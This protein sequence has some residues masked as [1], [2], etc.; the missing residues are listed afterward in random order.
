MESRVIA[1]G[2]SYTYG[3]ALD[4]SWYHLKGRTYGKFQPSNTA[5]PNLVAKQLDRSC[6][7]LSWPGGGP[8]DHAHR[9]LTWNDLKSSDIV[10]CLWS[11]H[12]RYVII[13]NDN[14]TTNL[15]PHRSDKFDKIYYKR[16]YDDFDSE[17]MLYHYREYVDLKCKSLGSVV[18][19]MYVNP[20]DLT[21]SKPNWCCAEW[22]EVTP[23]EV[24]KHKHPYAID[25]G[26]PGQLAHNEFA[27]EVF[28]IITR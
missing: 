5:W 28:K 1:V 23:L 2:C 14:K 16:Y 13:E 18:Y 9:F 8:K 12:P 17:I 24:I 25:N 10:L 4:D 26:H 27:D 19:H 3:Y 6:V 21:M 15:M 7:N 11:F 22:T 20:K